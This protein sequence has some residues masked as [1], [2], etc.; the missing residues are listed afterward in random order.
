[1][2]VSKIPPARGSTVMF[3][4]GVLTPVGPQKWVRCSAVVMHSKTSSLGASYTRV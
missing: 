1:M 3:S 4:T 2:M